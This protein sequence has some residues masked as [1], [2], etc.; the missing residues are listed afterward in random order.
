MMKKILWVLL[1]L[2]CLTA[3]GTEE[4]PEITQPPLPV[5]IE[6][7]YEEPTEEALSYEGV[8]V[9]FD[10][11]WQESDPAAQVLI[12]AQQLFEERTGA[13]VRILWPSQETEKADILQI[14]AADFETMDA[15]IALDLTEMAENAAYHEKSHAALQKQIVERM[16]YL[17]AVAQVPYLGGVYYNA[18]AFEECGIV[19]VPQTW[20]QFELLCATLME[21]GW[22]PLTMDKEDAVSAMELHLRRTIGTENMIRYMGKK[23]HWHFDQTVNKTMERVALLVQS[24]VMAYGTPA[25]YPA[26][27]NK[28]GISNSAMMIGT[29]A[30]CVAVEKDTLT[31]LC[32]GMFPYPG[33]IESGT[34]MTADMLVIHKDCKNAQA[35][36]DFVMLLVSG[37][38]DQLRANMDEG[39]PADPANTSPIAGA[40]E[41]L[42]EA[43]PK[44]LGIF[45]AKQTDAA[46][47]LW[48]AWYKDSSNYAKALER[49]K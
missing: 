35:A 20:E 40:M 46:V 8:E 14:S 30:D 18:D 11:I 27:Q 31:N 33:E 12:Q 21:K 7:P 10:A 44:A 39:I 42:Q 23:D 5:E 32:W 29:N 25:D 24:G 45:G 2:L 4:T 49:S 48:S 34:W 47:K 36:F 3:C 9:S 16:G 38:F 19:T 6:I 17:G 22:Q 28:M 41:A 13:K 1:A 43:E 26:G 37:E 15:E